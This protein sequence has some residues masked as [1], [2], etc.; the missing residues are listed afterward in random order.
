[1]ASQM[2]SSHGDYSARPDIPVTLIH[3][4]GTRVTANKIT[5]IDTL[6]NTLSSHEQIPYD[7]PENRGDLYILAPMRLLTPIIEESDSE[8]ARSKIYQELSTV[9]RNTVC[10]YSDVD[11]SIMSIISEVLSVRGPPNNQSKIYANQ[12][13]LRHLSRSEN[14]VDTN[15]LLS[16]IE[17]IRNNS[18]CNLY[19]T[20]FNDPHSNVAES[21]L[22][23]R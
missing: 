1:M 17:E 10:N 23:L 9:S 16:T 21:S 11:N 3:H 20:S 14:V 7:D 19:N 18:M 2:F 6:R 5:N 15:S 13:E 12:S 4:D 22:A 8:L